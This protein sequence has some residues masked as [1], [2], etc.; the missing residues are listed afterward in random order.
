MDSHLAA[1]AV[2]AH[3]TESRLTRPPIL[4]RQTSASCTFQ[5]YALRVASSRDRKGATSSAAYFA[6]SQLFWLLLGRRLSARCARCATSQDGSSQY[7]MHPA[8]RGWDPDM[9]TIP[10]RSSSEVAFAWLRPGKCQLSGMPLCVKC[11]SQ[12]LEQSV[13]PVHT[14][15]KGLGVILS[16]HACLHGGLTA[17]LISM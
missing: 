7:L 12:R 3:G 5:H 17:E 13:L 9:Y 4:E 2:A 11:G 1:T 10:R 14:S 16:M 6:S 8:R 15:V